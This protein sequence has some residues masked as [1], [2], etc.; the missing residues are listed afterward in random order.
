MDSCGENRFHFLQNNAYALF[1]PSVGNPFQ[2]NSSKFSQKRKER[3]KKDETKYYLILYLNTC[4]LL[5]C[6]FF[7]LL[8]GLV[9]LHILW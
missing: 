6:P 4:A 3:R 2:K 1:V 8:N 9:F 7:L 5:S